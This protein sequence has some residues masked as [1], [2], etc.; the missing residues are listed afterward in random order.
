MSRGGDAFE[1][2]LEPLEPRV[3]GAVHAL[4]HLE[5]ARGH[6]ARAIRRAQV[7]EHRGEAG[8]DHRGL[9]IIVLLDLRADGERAV[10]VVERVSGGA[11]IVEHGAEA[12]VDERQPVALRPALG[13]EDREGAPQ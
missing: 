13:L 5:R 3:I 11:E 8:Q 10:E 1:P 9:G 2:G 4:D 7:E 6:V 12:G